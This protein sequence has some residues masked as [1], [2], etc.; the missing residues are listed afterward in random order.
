MT[1]LGTCPECG[2]TA[3]LEA[4]LAE[5]GAAVPCV[6]ITVTN[7]AGGGQPVSLENIRATAKIARAH[8]KPFIIDGC[9]FAENAYFIQ[10]REPGQRIGAHEL[11]KEQV[12]LQQ[13]APKRRQGQRAVRDALHEGV[14]GVGL[15]LRGAGLLQPAEQ[16]ALG[17]VAGVALSPARGRVAVGGRDR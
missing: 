7:N 5:H 15:P 3:P 12:V 6:M 1:L 11:H 16:P 13:V 2:G 8:G 10:Q 17:T 9:R 4:Y 14:P